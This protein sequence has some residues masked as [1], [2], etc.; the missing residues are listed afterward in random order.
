MLVLEKNFVRLKG[1]LQGSHK[2]RENTTGMIQ[3]MKMDYNQLKDD[4]K[5]FITKQT[6]IKSVTA[7]VPSSKPH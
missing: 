6:K 4:I 2:Q 5:A 3:S 1:K 7:A